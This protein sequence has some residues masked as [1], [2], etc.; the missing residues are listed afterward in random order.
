MTITAD[1]THT[2]SLELSQDSQ[3]QILYAEYNLQIKF[4]VKDNSKTD[5]TTGSLTIIDLS[6]ENEDTQQGTITADK[7]IEDFI[8]Y[9]SGSKKV[10]FS[11]CQP[12]YCLNAVQDFELEY[13]KR[14]VIVNIIGN[15]V[16]II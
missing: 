15:A 12:S 9:K 3:T 7:A 14:P 6:D 4:S 1:S 16:R 11:L 10:Y 13:K 8:L 2:C 5:I